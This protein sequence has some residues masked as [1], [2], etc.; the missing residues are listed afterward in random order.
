LLVTIVWTAPGWAQSETAGV[1]IEEKLGQR[2]P[3]ELTFNAEDGKP[4]ALQSLFGKPTIL[5][6]VYYECPAICTPLLNGLADTLDRL[7]MEPGKDY[8][9]ITIS[10][11]VRD[12]PE[13]A[14]KK[15]ANY[16]KRF[17]KPFPPEAWRF[18][19]GNQA[20]IDKITDA[21][22]FRYKKA[23][24]D[25]NHPAVVT[26]LSPDGRI[27][28]YL[29]GISFMPFDIKMAVIEASKGR[30]MPTVNRVLAYCFACDPDGRKYVF[31]TL[32]VI[33]SVTVVMLAMFV[34]W[35]VIS[36]RRHEIMARR[37][38]SPAR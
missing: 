38:V 19:T 7:D 8:Q 10:F 2:V 26:V 3:P 5:T 18:L 16:L 17:H 1:G 15:R 6:L 29:Q 32:K 27:M 31:S 37:I 23:G 35:L 22:G 21:V 9:V 13:L 11:D 28:R 12:T 24:K 20:A 14:A 30:P 33:G 25:F 36:T 34:A 4:V